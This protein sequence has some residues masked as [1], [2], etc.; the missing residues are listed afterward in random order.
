MLARHMSR[1]IPGNPTIV[2]QNMPGAGSK[3]L[4]NYIYGVAPKDGTVFGVINEA[5]ANHTLFN[6]EGTEFDSVK[7]T[8]LGSLVSDPSICFSW[9]ESGITS[10]DDV[11]TGEFIVGAT[12]TGSTSYILPL[13]MINLLG[14][15]VKPIPGYK[16]SK[17][18]MLA[19]E[20]GEV[21]GMCGGSWLYAT[22][23]SGDH[24]PLP[25]PCR[26][27]SSEVPVTDP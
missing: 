21:Q 25:D 6:V 19:I 1:H 17:K 7:F 15:K 12:G 20:R 5:M 14:A 23:N 11:M 18:V 10:L 8:W 13:T 9:R 3:R 27:H 4:A 26:N 16:G 24:R 2:P 22:G